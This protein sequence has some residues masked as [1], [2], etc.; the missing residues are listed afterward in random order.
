MGAL[1][2]TSI[3]KE[4]GRTAFCAG[5]ARLTGREQS[6]P[7]LCKPIR[8]T[9]GNAAPRPDPDIAFYSEL[10]GAS[11]PESWPVS[12]GMTEA[13]R[14]L[15]PSTTESIVTAFNQMDRAGAVIIEGPPVTTPQGQPLP[16]AA[17]LAEMLDAQIVALVRYQPDLQIEESIAPLEALGD[18][19][20][21]VVLNGV[22]RYRGHTA[23]SSLT[24][25]L[26]AHG[27][28]VLGSVPEARCMLGVTVGQLVEHIKGTFLM[29]DEKRGELVDHVMIGGLVLDSGVDYFARY[30][31]KAVIV[32]GD[33][34]DIQMAALATPTRCLVLT[35][36]HH[37]IQYV[38]YEAREEEIPVVVVESDTL[39]TAR[40]LDT[41]FGGVTVHHPDK[42]DCYADL[43]SKSI[44]L[45][46]LRATLRGT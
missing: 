39:T 16:V 6:L 2:V 8:I 9:P 25:A 13:R 40:S 23:Q 44:D 46:P 30:Q 19:L 42:A 14:G 32:R 37:P 3:H 38:E 12:M 7:F 21:G 28:K 4:A 26:E 36:G 24:P 31:K 11:Q 34:P 22:P 41:L 15:N 5:L 45:E 20:L 17:S 1:L 18:R 27:L 10:T 35:G 29:G 43:L 33:R